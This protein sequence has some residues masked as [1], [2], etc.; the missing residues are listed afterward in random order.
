[1]AHRRSVTPAIYDRMLELRDRKLGLKAIAVIVSEE[2]GETFNHMAVKRALHRPRPVENRPADSPLAPPRKLV[3]G[4]YEPLIAEGVPQYVAVV[5]TLGTDK[6]DGTG[7]PTRSQATVRVEQY[8][9]IFHQLGE[10]D[11]TNIARLL[12]QI[13]TMTAADQALYATTAKSI[14]G[15][16][17]SGFRKPRLVKRQEAPRKKEA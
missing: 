9:K 3:T 6:L 4:E 15:V 1:M 14:L 17:E 5:A 7:A 11:A 8:R 13:D 10:A 2:F 16:K 12:N